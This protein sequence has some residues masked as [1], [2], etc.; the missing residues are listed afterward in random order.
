MDSNINNVMNYA[1]AVNGQQMYGNVG[2]GAQIPPK[3]IQTPLPPVTNT[4]Q[5]TS[6]ETL[7]SYSMGKI[8]RLPDFADG[9]EFYARI[10][11]PSLLKMVKN[12]KIPNALLS[13]ANKLFTSSIDD[14]DVEN[15]NM[16]NDLFS[17]MDA[18]CDASFVE[19]TYQQILDAG[20]ELTDEQYMFIFDY[21]QQGAKSL[22]PI[23]KE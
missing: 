20:I 5:V 6:I 11:R 12:G 1:E 13:T 10:R 15:P 4:P 22:T 9:Q 2:V 7:Q 17:V 3:G 18:I 14:D 21:S 16:M 23:P 19:P 8:E